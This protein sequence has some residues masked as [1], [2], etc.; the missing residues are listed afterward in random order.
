MAAIHTCEAAESN[1]CGRPV[2]PSRQTVVIA[3]NVCCPDWGPRSSGRRAMMGLM[4]L[5]SQPAMDKAGARGVW[6]L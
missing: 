5:D 4:R 3:E 6:F 1:S 2:Q